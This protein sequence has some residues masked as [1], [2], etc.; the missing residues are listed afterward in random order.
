MVH[1]MDQLLIVKAREVLRLNRFRYLWVIGWLVAT[2]AL[3]TAGIQTSR[4]QEVERQQ[5]KMSALTERLESV[6]HQQQLVNDNF[7]KAWSNQNQTAE[8]LITW[9]DYVKA[10]TESAKSNLGLPFQL[11]RTR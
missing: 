8:L 2:A 11:A 4:L 3:V 5:E 10:R 6:A 7:V 1:R 9:G